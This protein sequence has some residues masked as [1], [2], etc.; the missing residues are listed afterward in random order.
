MENYLMSIVMPVYNTEKYIKNTIERVITQSIFEK[1]ELIIIDDGSSDRSSIICKEYSKKYENI[2]YKRINNSGVSIARNYGIDMAQGEYI[3]FLDSD[4]IV[5]CDLYQKEYEQMKFGEFD[6]GFFDFYKNFASGEI[7]KYRKKIYK[8]WNDRDNIIR[9]FFS[10]IIGNQVVEK[11]FAKDIAKKVKFNPQYKIGEDMDYVYNVLKL[12]DKAVM[13]TEICGYHYMIR[14]NSAMTGKF[15]I[16][17]FDP[18][19]V[20]K[21]MCLEYENNYILAPYAKAHL[22]HEM[23]KSLEYAYKN[24]APKL[25]KEQIEDIKK[26]IK[27]YKILEAKKYLVNKQWYGFLLMKYFPNLYMMVYKILKIG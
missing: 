18:I 13:N 2:K 3:T 27:K 11:V 25:Y 22:I 5:D 4:D 26:Y 8:Q 15:E 12:V 14:K 24:K 9:D 1:L 10:G 16:K 7:V 23:C 19:I 21:R 6:V 20:S 17:Y